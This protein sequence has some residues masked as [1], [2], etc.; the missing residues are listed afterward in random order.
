MLIGLFGFGED[1]CD[2]G[3]EIISLFG[4]VIKLV[5]EGK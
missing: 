4:I 3:V 2:L 5:D 1:N